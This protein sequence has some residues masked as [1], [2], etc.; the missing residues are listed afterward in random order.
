MTGVCS[1]QHSGLIFRWGV[2]FYRKCSTIS[3]AAPLSQAGVQ[4]WIFAHKCKWSLEW[5]VF[6]VVVNIFWCSEYNHKYEREKERGGGK[7]AERG[8]GE[9][10]EEGDRRGKSLVVL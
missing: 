3:E 10:E 6:T 7:E 2:Q 9:M 4:V 5:L 1:D 8:G